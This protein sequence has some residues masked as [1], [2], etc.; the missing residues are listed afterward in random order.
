[1]TRPGGRLQEPQTS[2]LDSDWNSTKHLLNK[3]AVA[4]FQNPLQIRKLSGLA[5]RTAGSHTPEGEGRATQRSPARCG[6]ET[7]HPV[8]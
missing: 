4:A 1:M 3:R 8:A 5:L 6:E 7:T 2:C